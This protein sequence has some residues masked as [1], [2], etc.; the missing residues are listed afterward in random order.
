MNQYLDRKAAERLTIGKDATIREAMEVIDR[1]AINVAV[2]VD[3]QGRAVGLVSDGDIRRGLLAGREMNSPV[4]PLGNHTFFSVSPSTGRSEV[5]DLMQARYLMQVPIIDDHGYLV[6]MHTLRGILGGTPKPNIAVIM[7]GGKGTRLGTITKSLPKPMIQ[8][9]GRPILERLLLHLVGYGIS[10]IYLAV[11]HLAEIIE[12]HFGDGSEFGCTISYLKEDQPMGTGGALNLLPAPP[13]ED[14]L[15]MNGDLIIQVDFDTMLQDHARQKRY[16]TM[17]VTPYHHRI[18][19]G[20]V[21]C[22]DN[23]HITALEEKPLVQKLVNAGVYVLSPDA[24][25]NIPEGSFPIT[26]LFEEAVRDAKPCGTFLVEDCLDVGQPQQLA[27]A[28][29][30]V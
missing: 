17:A 23:G 12:A 22:G 18:A 8:V 2:I 30:S 19:F 16:A 14:I 3:P 26:Q 29:G 13:E 15:V 10:R 25:K 7:A 5:L 24:V 21:E 20:C 11:N 1:G 9:A 6:G 4:L 28:R 27:Q